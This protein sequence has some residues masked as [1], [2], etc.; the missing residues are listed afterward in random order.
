MSIQYPERDEGRTALRRMIEVA[1]QA[2][3]ITAALA[4]LYGY[5]HPSQFEQDIERFLKGLASAV[6]DQEDR[7]TRLEVS[8][9]PRLVVSGLAL[10]VA[11]HMLRINETAHTDLLTFD[12]LLQGFPGID[13]V[14]IEDAVAE[15]S[16]RQYVE[17]SAAIGHPI[18]IISSGPSLFLAFDLAATGRNTRADALKIAKLWSE[19]SEMRSV[20]KLSEHLGWEP[21][22]LNPALKVLRHVFPD[23]R[24][25]KS[26]HPTFTTTS[27]V[28]TP[29]E[30]FK[31]RSMIENGRVD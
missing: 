10:E 13:K 2:T 6:N 9:S 3:T 22:R 1:A 18:R 8:F 31:L 4:H 7:I 27:V 28:V 15:L 21:R 17:T 30:R 12:R 25:S 16:V 23:G 5:T 20:V 29:E 24:W 11:V 14:A 19:N 26:M